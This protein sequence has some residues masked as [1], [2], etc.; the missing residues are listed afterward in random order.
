MNKKKTF[1]FIIIL[2]ANL[3]YLKN[4]LN[5]LLINKTFLFHKICSA[6]HFN[7]NPQATKVFNNFFTA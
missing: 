7:P 2:C 6:I 5:F 3:L 4:S 1:P